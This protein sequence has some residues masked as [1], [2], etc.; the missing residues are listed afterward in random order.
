MRVMYQSLSL[1][2]RW[3]RLTRPF[4]TLVNETGLLS[5]MGKA[6]IPVV[7]VVSMYHPSGTESSETD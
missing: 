6:I 3:P 5:V 7:A 2:M 1:K 4:L